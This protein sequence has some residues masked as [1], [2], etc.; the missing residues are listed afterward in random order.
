MFNQLERAA[1]F[2]RECD[3]KNAS[4]GGILPALEIIN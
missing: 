3:E 4:P 2:R 1:R